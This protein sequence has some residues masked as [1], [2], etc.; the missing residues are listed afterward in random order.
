[1]VGGYYAT[2]DHLVNNAKVI[3][4]DSFEKYSQFT[5][6]ASIM[7]IKPICF[8]SNFNN[9]VVTLIGNKTIV[10]KKSS[11]HYNC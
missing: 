5:D 6:V 8:V 11:N 3:R 9:N 4:V 7:L 1:M 10:I 2:V